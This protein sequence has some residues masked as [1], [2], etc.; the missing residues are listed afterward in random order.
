MWAS[1]PRT[2]NP[3]PNLPSCLFLTEGQE[4]QQDQEI[5][6]TSQVYLRWMLEC[7]EVPA[8]VLRLLC[9]RPVLHAAADPHREDALPLRRRGDVFQ[10]RHDDPVLQVQLQLPACQ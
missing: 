9:G 6:G 5:P 7:E 3:V 4:V 1:P 10:E 2:T 8:Q